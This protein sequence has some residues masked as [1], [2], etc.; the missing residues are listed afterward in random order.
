M[1]WLAAFFEL[2][3]ISPDRLTALRVYV[4][5]TYAVCQAVLWRFRASTAVILDDVDEAAHDLGLLS[6]VVG[7]L[8]TERFSAARLATLRAELN[9][10]GLPASRRIAR[11]HKLT[12]LVGFTRQRVRPAART[13]AVVGRASHLRHRTVAALVGTGVAP[14]AGRR[15]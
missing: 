8:E 6:G 13:V 15:R 11:L 14:L 1:A 2:L 3:Q 9:V 12:D 4:L 10:E 7:R 5:L